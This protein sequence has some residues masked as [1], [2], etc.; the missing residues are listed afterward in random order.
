MPDELRDILR[1][2]VKE[3]LSRDE[4]VSS[5]TVRLCRSIEIARIAATAGFDT[6]YVDV[7]HNTLSIDAVCQ[8][9]VSALQCQITPLVRVPANSPEFI[10]RLLD[11]GAMGVIAPH[12]RSA[13][14]AREV[15]VSPNSRHRA[16]AERW[17]AAAL[18]L[19]QLS[20]RCSEPSHE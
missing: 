6:I 15:Y 16:N 3:K 5:M 8:I 13:E 19:S 20:F 10:C 2:R 18:S 4:V 9:C 12:V 1:N 11:G 14:E 7:E 17:R